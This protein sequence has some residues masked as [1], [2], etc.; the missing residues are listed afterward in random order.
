MFWKYFISEKPG[1]P[2]KETWRQVQSKVSLFEPL[3]KK[4]KCKKRT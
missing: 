1:Y 2:W 4:E 3:T